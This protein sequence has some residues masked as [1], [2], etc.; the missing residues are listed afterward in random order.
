MLSSTEPVLL[1]FSSGP[2]CLASCGPVLL[3]W[4]AAEKRR[5]A[6][7]MRLLAVF[8][9]GRFAGYL[10]FAVAAW[11]A[12]AAL[13]AAGHPVLY[14][15]VHLGIAGV[16]AWQAVHL[17]RAEKRACGEKCLGCRSR[18][19]TPAALG[20]LTGVTLCPP[21]LVAT[22]RAAETGSL[23]L[24][25]AFFALFFAGTAAWFVPLATVGWLRRLESLGQVARLVMLILALYYAYLGILALAGRLL[26]G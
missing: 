11:A 8:L 17:A 9:A 19:G 13:P 24:S 26:H 6:E 21:F 4:L 15:L 16:L 25:V 20:F 10:V 3:P 5:V 12:G 22:A 1:G 18:S 14:G 7:T 23:A 2:A